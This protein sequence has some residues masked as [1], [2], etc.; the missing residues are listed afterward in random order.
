MRQS[1]VTYTLAGTVLFLSGVIVGGQTNQQL[2]Q[3]R[4]S[5]QI[6]GQRLGG[7]QANLE[8]LRSYVRIA[9]GP[10]LSKVPI[11]YFDQKTRKIH[12]STEVDG[13]IADKMPAE[14]LKI[15]LRKAV[16]RSWFAVRVAFPTLPGDV[17]TGA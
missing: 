10:P 9:E 8:L 6:R 7:I 17:A 12:A 13:P 14:D 11:V 2:L 5:L 3:I 15:N 16:L 1:A 4:D